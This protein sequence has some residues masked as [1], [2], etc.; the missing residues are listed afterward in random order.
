MADFLTQSDYYC[1][2]VFVPNVTLLFFQ[3][4]MYY[5][6]L[7]QFS[8]LGHLLQCSTQKY[9]VSK[10]KSTCLMTEFFFRSVFMSKSVKKAECRH[11]FFFLPRKFIVWRILLMYWLKSIGH[12]TDI[13]GSIRTG[14]TSGPLWAHLGSLKNGIGWDWVFQNT[15]GSGPNPSLTLALND[16]PEGWCC[17]WKY[18]IIFIWAENSWLWM[19]RMLWKYLINALRW[20]SST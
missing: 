16:Y 2:A 6:T 19:Y 5:K 1:W 14:S 13:L 15:L 3:D 18:L 10:N 9:L 7:S 11:S 12:F 17:L 4:C 20:D 8:I